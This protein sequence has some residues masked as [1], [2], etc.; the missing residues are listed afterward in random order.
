MRTLTLFT[1]F[2]GVLVLSPPAPAQTWEVMGP[3]G[4]SFFAANVDPA[5]SNNITLFGRDPAPADV[6]Q[7]T[8]GGASWSKIGLIPNVYFYLDEMASPNYST[9][10]GCGYNSTVG[11]SCW[12]STDGGVT[13]GETVVTDPYQNARAVASHPSIPN[14][15]YLAGNYNDWGTSTHIP[16][17][18]KSTDG[19]QT[20]SSMD[21]TPVSGYNVFWSIAVAATDPNL[22]YMAGM[23]YTPTYDALALVYKSTDGGATWTDISRVVDTI[24]DSDIT[25]ITIDPTNSNNVYAASYKYFYKSTDGG[26][27]WTSDYTTYEYPRYVAVNPGD[28][29]IIYMNSWYDKLYRS[30][31][32]G[33]TFTEITGVYSGDPGQILADPSNPSTVYLAASGSGFHQSNDWGVTWQTAHNG[34]NAAS[35]SCLALA[36]SEP[37]TGF[38][39]YLGTYT[40]LAS[41]DGFQNY[42]SMAYPPQCTTGTIGEILVC[43]TNADLVMALEQG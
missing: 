43:S 42:T 11:C 37:T 13:W 12:Y 24:N 5:N 35:I 23:Q 21:L 18:Y 22:V 7:T 29:S 34:I 6:F 30:T 36:P 33:A 41:Q 14:T 39:G 17:F 19:G 10:Y 27:T 2:I 16:R 15:V 1:L 28:P 3:E 26:V 25:C 8:D 40:I 31:D 9:Y 32:S 38:A 4:G 20:F